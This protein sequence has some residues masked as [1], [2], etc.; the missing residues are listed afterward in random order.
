MEPPRHIPAADIKEQAEGDGNVQ[1]DPEDAGPDD[2]AEADCRLEIGQPLDE[3]AA[4]QRRRRPDGDVEEAA[5]KV[6]ADTQL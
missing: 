3:G 6:D 5:E 1:G 4:R 2:G